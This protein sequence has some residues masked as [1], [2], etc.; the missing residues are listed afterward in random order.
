[1][2]SPVH[3]HPQRRDEVRAWFPEAQGK[4]CG[5]APTCG[6]NSGLETEPMSNRELV[7]WAHGPGPPHRVVLDMDSSRSLE[8]SR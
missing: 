5:S 2:L 4:A 6:S 3:D 8:A 1:M 7:A